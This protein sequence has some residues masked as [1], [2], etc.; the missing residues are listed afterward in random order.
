LFIF[1]GGG[2]AHLESFR[3]ILQES[4]ISEVSRS[5]DFYHGIAGL[6]MRGSSLEI[7]ATVAMA[8]ADSPA[9][10]ISLLLL[11]RESSH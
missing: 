8:I 1:C 4:R 7:V 11:F 2:G 9:N 5:T 10:P 6:P 3:T